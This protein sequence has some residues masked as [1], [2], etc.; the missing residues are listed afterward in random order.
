MH[1]SL[2]EAGHWRGT[3]LPPDRH[4]A[5]RLSVDAATGKL[6]SRWLGASAP[7][8]GGNSGRHDE[9]GR[10]LNRPP[11]G[12]RTSTRGTFSWPWTGEVEDH[13]ECNFECQTELVSAG[14]AAVS[15]RPCSHLSRSTRLTAT[16]E[17]S[18][19]T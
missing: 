9:P 7:S 14:W 12:T 17:Q 19:G 10:G 4:R 1:R 3:H 13:S 16:L 5:R 2:K 15:A 8:P 6:T 11:A 18:G